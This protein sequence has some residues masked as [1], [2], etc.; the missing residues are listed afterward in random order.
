MGWLLGTGLLLVG[1]MLIVGVFVIGGKGSK[2]RSNPVKEMRHLSG[3]LLSD[4]VELVPELEKHIREGNFRAV[5]QVVDK[6]ESYESEKQEIIRQHL[7]EAGVIERYKT[8]LTDIDYKIRTAG[9]E[10][11]GKVG[12]EEV[13][14]LLFR[15]MA[16]KN[17]EVRLAATQALK[18]L[19]EPA[20]SG[21]LVGA[22]KEPYRWLPARVAEVLISLGKAGVP[23][24]QEALSESDPTY[25][26]YVIEIL[27]EIGDPSSAE[28]LHPALEDTNGNIRLQA[29]RALGK[30]GYNGSAGLLVELLQDREIKVKVQAIRS[31]GKIGD[32]QAAPHLAEL[33]T[34]SD[35]VVRY[36]ALEALRNMG[37][38]GLEFIAK[39]NIT[40]Q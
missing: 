32:P 31:L 36:A 30:I 1:I 33:L 9:A 19:K 7:R 39:V 23:A 17:E 37:R 15:A 38:E 2:T 28:A 12:G 6:M 13:P 24:L 26:G 27:G 5:D 11:L 22:L 4:T 40:Y 21:L 20:I 16:D 18:N 29:A 14:E 8:D 34:H 3:V 35:A 10:R 25:R